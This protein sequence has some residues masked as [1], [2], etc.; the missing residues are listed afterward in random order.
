MKNSVVELKICARDRRRLYKVGDVFSIDGELHMLVRVSYYKEAYMCSLS[1]G[2]R[3]EDNVA[4]RL[5]EVEWLDGHY[6]TDEDI[7]KYVNH[8]YNRFG[9]YREEWEYV[10]RLD[11]QYE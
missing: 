1:T 7:D 5:F 9:D 6:T 8:S 11:V 3:W 4:V 2:N 10:G